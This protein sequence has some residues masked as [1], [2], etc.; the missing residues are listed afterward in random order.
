[1]I[2]S[3][4][5][6]FN[7]VE[8]ISDARSVLHTRQIISEIFPDHSGIELRVPGILQDGARKLRLKIKREYS[9]DIDFSVI[10]GLTRGRV[11]FPL[12]FLLAR[13]KT[14]FALCGQSLPFKVI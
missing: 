9:E 4:R 5:P 14:T 12:V 8:L 10:H 3:A 13:Q 1:M 7:S 11:Q 6:L 2:V